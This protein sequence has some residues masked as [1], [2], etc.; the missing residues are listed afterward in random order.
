MAT[1]EALVFVKF[2]PEEVGCLCKE[3]LVFVKFHPEEVGC[4]CIKHTRMDENPVH[5]VTF[6]QITENVVMEVEN[7]QE[8]APK[9]FPPVRIKQKKMKTNGFHP[10]MKLADFSLLKCSNLRK[11]KVTLLDVAFESCGTQ[12]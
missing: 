9:H 3:A 5:P 1:E 8:K 2:H 10:F 7:P 4:L 12:Q 6:W 11:T